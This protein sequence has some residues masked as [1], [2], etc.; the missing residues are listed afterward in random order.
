MKPNVPWP[1][2]GDVLFTSGE[3]W[4]N[5]CVGWS[6]DQWF[7]FKEGYRRSAMILTQHIADKLQD[8]DVLVY[9]VAFLYRQALEISLKHLIWLGRQLQDEEAS[10]PTHHKLVPLWNICQA[11]I[12]EV[13][14]DGKKEDLEAVSAVLSQFESRDPSSTLFRYPLTKD[15]QVPFTHHENIDIGNFSTVIERVFAFLDSC[16]S[17]FQT[18]LDDQREMEREFSSYRGG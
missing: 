4:L 6:R 12:E 9:P 5:A 15:G 10:F 16:A 18:Y 14:P 2:V 8:Q 17:A 11:M 3:N 1:C 7:G 13:W